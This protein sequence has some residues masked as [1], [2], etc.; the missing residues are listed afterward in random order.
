MFY[1]RTTIIYNNSVLKY[2]NDKIELYL[3]QNGWGMIFTI[4]SALTVII[5]NKT[6]EFLHILLAT[7]QYF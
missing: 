1:L 2:T 7:N 3:F 5:L 4:K 6:N